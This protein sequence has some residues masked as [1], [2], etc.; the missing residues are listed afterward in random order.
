MLTLPEIDENAD[1]YSSKED[2]ALLQMTG[3]LVLAA[4]GIEM[5]IGGVILG[6][7]GAR[8]HRIYKRRLDDLSMNI[9]CTPKQQG[10]MLTLRF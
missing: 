9:I 6:S 8:K 2:E 1:D 7:V 5:F 4:V 3:G 10:I